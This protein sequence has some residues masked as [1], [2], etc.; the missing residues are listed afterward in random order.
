ML[1]ADR[2]RHQDDPSLAA[3]QP[4]GHVVSVRGSQ[5]TVGLLNSPLQDWDKVRSTVGKF[6]GIRAGNSLL[7][8]VI[9]NVSIETPALAKELGCHSTA[10]LDLVGE[11]KQAGMAPA[12]FQRGVTEY[13]AIGDPVLGISAQELRLVFNV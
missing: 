5:A 8:G 2:L 10:D 4:I 3:G 6:L 1:T 7:I 12:Q 13:P 11:I 9:T